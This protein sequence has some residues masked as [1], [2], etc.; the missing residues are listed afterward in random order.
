MYHVIQDVFQRIIDSAINFHPNP[1][2]YVVLNTG[3]QYLKNRKELDIGSK[4]AFLKMQ[5]LRNKE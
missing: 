5:L 1:F 3:T 4:C 2:N